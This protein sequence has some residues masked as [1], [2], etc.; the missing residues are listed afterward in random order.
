MKPLDIIK[1]AEEARFEDEN[2]Y[3]EEFKM[4]PPLTPEE[5]RQL[6][7]RIPCPLPSETRELLEYCRGFDGVLESIDFSGLYPEFGMEEVFPHGV[8]IAHDGFGNYWVVDLSVQTETWSPIFF[9]CHD[10]PVVVFQTDNLAHFISEV[11]KLGHPPWKS[12]ISD[13]HETFHERIWRENPGLL[14]CQQGLQSG[15]PDLVK[16]AENLDDSWWMIDLREAAIGDG[17][18]WG[19][20]GPATVNRRF[21]EK[22]IFAVQKKKTLLQRMFNR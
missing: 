11:I 20:Y 17:F 7:A 3:I 19:R 9:V 15:D 13:V 16:F 1:Q 8:P 5:F 2:G 10:A 12:E 18:S 4:L 22:R 6:E 14:T 21:G